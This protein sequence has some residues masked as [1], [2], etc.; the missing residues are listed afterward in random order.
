MSARVERSWRDWP[1]EW[2]LRDVTERLSGMLAALRL[3]AL[4]AGAQVP[5]CVICA[6]AALEGLDTKDPWAAHED[7]CQLVRQATRAVREASP[8]GTG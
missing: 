8:A 2:R 1:L 4:P 6:Q 5:Q 3:P 7:W